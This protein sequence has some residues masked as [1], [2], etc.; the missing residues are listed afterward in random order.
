MKKKFVAGLAAGLLM[1]GPAGSVMADTI[2]YTVTIDLVPDI[3]MVF[4]TNTAIQSWVF[5]IRDNAGWNTPNQLFSNGSITLTVEDDGG[6]GDGA[7]KATFVFD[8]GT[9]LTNRQINSPEWGWSF[10]VD[11]SQFT[12]G[13]ISATLTATKGD[14]YFRSARLNV[15]SE[16]TP[17]QLSSNPVPEPA[18]MILFGA[19]LLGLAVA[20]RR[21]K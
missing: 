7:E 3:L 15:T 5:D 14:F 11:R 6:G 13:L 20:V 16:F 17:P 10:I 19:G 1:L 4:G 12:D 18:T 21:K 8:G 2:A 9:G